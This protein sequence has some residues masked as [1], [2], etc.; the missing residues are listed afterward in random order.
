M[1][2]S[3]M[4]ERRNIDERDI[5]RLLAALTDTQIASVFG[6]TEEEVFRLRQSRQSKPARAQSE[7]KSNR[8]TKS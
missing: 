8:E 5:D 2:D 4:V 1:K 6:M 7:Q 3:M